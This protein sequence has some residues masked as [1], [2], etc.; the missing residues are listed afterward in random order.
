MHNDRILVTGG[1]GFIGSHTV[2]T[3]V[4]NGYEVTVLDNLS[5]GKLDNIKSYVDNGDIKFIKGDIRN[6]NIVKKAIQG[7]IA[8]IHLAAIGS[9][10]QS[11]KDPLIVNSVN[12]NGTINVLNSAIRSKIS[13]SIFA[14]SAAVYGDAEP[15]HREELRLMAL[16]PYAATKIAGEYF[17]ESFQT[18]YELPAWIL[19]YFNVYRP[20]MKSD[21]YGSVIISFGKKIA[22]NRQPIING[23]GKQVRDHTC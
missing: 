4:E 14:S 21:T 16:S 17:C 23:D 1:A 11:I 7:C 20:R 2:D 6:H 15:P 19:R 3:L 9:V 8:V 13:K 5:T 12:V 18:S 22:A 10:P